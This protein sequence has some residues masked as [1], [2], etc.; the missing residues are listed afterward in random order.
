MVAQEQARMPLPSQGKERAL[1]LELQR[2][3]QKSFGLRTSVSLQVARSARLPSLWKRH[4][5]ER[6]QI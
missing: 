1:I 4:E 5:L 3:G 2:H 6:S